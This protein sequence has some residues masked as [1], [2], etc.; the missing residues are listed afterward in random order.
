[1]TN[2]DCVFCKIIDGEIPT[3]K[4]LENDKVVAFYDAKP[5]AD[6]HVLIVPKE[7]LATFL[8]IGRPEVLDELRQSA[9]RL[10]ADLELGPG[11][12]LVFNGGRY[13]HVPHLHWH[14][15]GGNFKKPVP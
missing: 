8:D 11:Y 15:L 2:S 14:L 4:I 3:N 5:S 12:R 1:M 6:V 7:H 13:Q 9:Q 10:I